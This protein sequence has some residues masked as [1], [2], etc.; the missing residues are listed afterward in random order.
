MSFGNSSHISPT[1]PAASLC[2][3]LS[4]LSDEQHADLH[5]VACCWVW[6]REQLKKH[7]PGEMVE[8]HDEMFANG[9]LILKNVQNFGLAFGWLNANHGFLKRDIIPDTLK[10]IGRQMHLASNHGSPNVFG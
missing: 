2:Q 8:K 1:L 9:W 3:K 10:I 7:F 4:Q 5:D 6:I